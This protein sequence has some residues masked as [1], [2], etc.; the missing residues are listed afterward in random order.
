[1]YYLN[2]E[3]PDVVALV[4]QRSEPGV[5]G[6]TDLSDGQDPK[7]ATSDPRNLK[8]QGLQNGFFIYS[9]SRLMGSL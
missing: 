3:G 1:M 5:L 9:G 8:K 2:F 4:V 6:V 7:I